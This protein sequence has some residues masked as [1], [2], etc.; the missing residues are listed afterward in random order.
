MQ[1]LGLTAVYQDD[2]DIMGKYVRCAFGLLFLPLNY[3]DDIWMEVVGSVRNEDVNPTRFVDYVTTTYVDEFSAIFSRE[4]WPQ[5]EKC[6]QIQQES[7][8]QITILL[9]WD[10][11]PTTERSCPQEF[12]LVSTF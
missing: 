6:R 10:F 3:V 1:N 7:F 2:S 5:A 8:G 11:C 9:W 12:C 4:V